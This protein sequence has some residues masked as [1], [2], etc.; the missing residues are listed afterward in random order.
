MNMCK[1][2]FKSVI[3]VVCI[4]LFCG[5]IYFTW[6][7]YRR[8]NPPYSHG[9]NIVL[10]MAGDNRAELEKVL[11]RYSYNP[12]DSL[13]LRAAE[14]LIE[15]MPG[16][17]S[18]EYEAPF[19]NVAA[20]Y[21]Q[22]DGIEDWQSVNEAYNWGKQIIREDVKCIT[23]DYLINNIELAFKVWEEQPWGK[24]VPFDV[25]CEEILPYRVALEPLENW[26]ERILSSYSKHDN[27]FRS[28]PGTTSIDACVRINSSLP[29]LRLMAR[30]PEM[31]YSMIMTTTRGMCD[32]MSALA[33][34]VM[35]ALG[36]PVSQDYTPV[37]PHR[38]VGH[39]WN[40]VYDSGRRVSF[41]GTEANPGVSHHGS[42]IPAS[43]VYRKTYARQKNIDIDDAHIPSI[44]S[45]Q[46]MKDVTD[47]YTPLPSLAD[48]NKEIQPLDAVL[49]P[50]KAHKDGQRDIEI[51]VKYLPSKTT[52]Y[53]YLAV[54][55]DNTWNITGWGKNDSKSMNFGTIGREILHL[56]MY[57]E[58]NTLIPANYPF[59]IYKNDSIRIFEPDEN[60]YRQISISEIFPAEDRYTERMINGVF[61][62]AN[63]SDFSDA[64]VLYTVKE[65]SGM[66]FNTVKIQN[67][68]RYRYIRYVSPEK[69]HCHVAE[70]IFYNDK[71][72]QLRG[73]PVG[74]PG[75]YH[76]SSMTFDKALDGDISTFYDALLYSDSWMG[77]ELNEPQTIAKIQYLPRNNGNGIYEKHK[78]ELYYWKD[79]EWKF[80]ERQISVTH[81]L[82]FR[83][84]TNAVLYLKNV[85]ANKFGKWFVVNKNG[86]QEWL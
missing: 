14:F 18:L 53:A 55:G 71:G 69:S 74:M 78:Y 10:F 70:I 67:P 39:T 56:P 19:E 43:K 86:E 76:N 81:P 47:E 52:G 16:K 50:H 83:V 37:W 6:Q 85:T 4:L 48:P 2:N 27:F 21:M 64:K 61:E 79:R 51:P 36:I 30:M 12:A 60:D 68:N 75:S 34:F 57:Y 73:K 20:V 59:M 44:L 5:M 29:R 72:E 7:R 24:D 54:V 82:Y 80:L 11:K 25:F 35:R 22:W 1:K 28:H 45:H 41:M 33:I 42:R 32:E 65:V 40:S 26:R 63:K 58:N 13:K 23:G 77:L 46:Y 15:N 3:T 66:Y 49:Q 38:N 8:N 9:I 62:G 17:Y 31:N 84:P